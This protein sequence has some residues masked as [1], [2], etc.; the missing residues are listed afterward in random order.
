[1][2]IP[3]AED[4][5]NI[6]PDKIVASGLATVGAVDV[7]GTVAADQYIE[8]QFLINAPLELLITE[9]ASIDMDPELVDT[10]DFPEDLERMVLYAEYD[11]QFE[12][13]TQIE[14]FAAHDTAHFLSGT[15]VLPDTLLTLDIIANHTGTDSVILDEDE[16]D[17]FDG[18]QELYVKTSAHLTGETDGE[19]NPLPSKFLSTDSLKILLYGAIKVLVDPEAEEED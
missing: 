15:T 14:V 6:S 3:N 11:N 4:L 7:I 9:D 8:G 19:G 1:M 10:D 5:I 2:R 13:G 18:S 12:F 17:L 16:F